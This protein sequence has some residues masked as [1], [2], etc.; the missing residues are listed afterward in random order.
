MRGPQGTLFGKN[1]LTGAINVISAKPEIGGEFGGQ[2]SLAVE[3]ENSANII[4]GHLNIPAGDTFAVRLSFKDRED[5]G[6]IT[7]AY[8]NTT[9]PTA[10]EQLLRLSASWQP[11]DDLRIDMKHTDGE[12]V[13]I[14]S[15]AVSY[16][17]L[18]L[19]T[20]PYV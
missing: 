12:H 14:G 4:D 7:N 3:D 5:D 6:Y 8:L 15:T 18:T 16:T 19:P 13:R 11:S 20:T 2:I 1:T 9:G 17:H 10:D